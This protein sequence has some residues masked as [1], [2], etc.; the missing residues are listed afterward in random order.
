MSTTRT[1]AIWSSRAQPRTTA[2]VKFPTAASTKARCG[3][4]C[5]ALCRRG[6]RRPA[7]ALPHRG[8]AD[9]R[10]AARADLPH[11]P[12]RRGDAARAWTTATAAASTA[13]RSPSCWWSRS[14]SSSPTRSVHVDHSVTFGGYYCEVEGRPP[15]HRG[16]AGCGSR[17]ACARSWPPT[18]RSARS[19]CRWPRPSSCSA[20]AAK[21]T[22][23]GCCSTGTRT[24]SSSTSCAGSAATSTATWCRRPAT[25]PLRASVLRRPGFV[26]RFP[27]ARRAWSWS[28]SSTIPS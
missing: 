16:G 10:R 6:R 24:T 8:R 28:R 17:S 12:R 4:S 26:L 22:R 25:S 21:T 23:C 20:A 19:A 5:D 15:V 7:L 9:R 14:T 18:R 11:R 3:P 2:Q 1:S 27:P 13:A